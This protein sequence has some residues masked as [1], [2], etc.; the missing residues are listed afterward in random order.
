MLL[1]LLS[2]AAPQAVE[3]RPPFDAD[4]AQALRREGAAALKLAPEFRNSLGMTLL[5]IPAGRFAMGVKGSK[6]AVELKQPYY[7]GRSEVTQAEYRRF[8]PG[9]RVPG[10][11]PAF[12]ADDLP[13]ASVSWQDARDYAAWLGEQPEERAAGRRYALPTEAQWEWAARAG[14]EGPR[15]CGDAPA[16][17]EAHAWF[18]HAYTPNPKTEANGRGRHPVALLKP[19]AWGLHDLYGNVW[20]WC[21]DRRVDP[22]TGET[23][24][25]VLRGGGWRS[26][27]SHCTSESRDPGA[28][29]LRA[30][31]VGFRLACVIRPP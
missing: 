2:L 15:H 10:E 3:A 13:A 24:D 4:R 28:P 19:N 9:H 14:T 17:L 6:Y 12:E 22:A 18:N 16:E 23:R 26:G 31:H 27:G 30:D 7:L 25:P 29:G 11:D 20:E 21:D 8:K 1:L 5:F